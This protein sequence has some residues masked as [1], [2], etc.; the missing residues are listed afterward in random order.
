M[1]LC[2]CID[3]TYKFIL[4]NSKNDWLLHKLLYIAI[5]SSII[6]SFL[7]LV[8]L[9]YNSVNTACVSSLLFV[10]RRCSCVQFDNLYDLLIRRLYNKHRCS[11][12]MSL[13]LYLFTSP[14]NYCLDPCLCLF[15]YSI[16]SL[17]FLTVNTVR[18]L[19][20]KINGVIGFT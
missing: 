11:K 15:T 12:I 20:S 18:V 16:F 4:Y 17:S 2:R 14:I 19:F 1:V 7:Y 8:I 10:A 13:T 9:S 6:C 5:M 3:Y